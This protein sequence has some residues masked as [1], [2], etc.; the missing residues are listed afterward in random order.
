MKRGELISTIVIAGIVS[1]ALNETTSGKSCETISLT[2]TESASEI[3]KETPTLDNQYRDY[4]VDHHSPD[5][6]VMRFDRLEPEEHI[7]RYKGRTRPRL[8]FY[9][10]AAPVKTTFYGL[11]DRSRDFNGR[12]PFNLPVRLLE[13]KDKL[14]LAVP[15]NFISPLGYCRLQLRLAGR[16]VYDEAKNRA[17]AVHTGGMLEAL[18]KIYDAERITVEIEGIKKQ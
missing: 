9:Q 4:I 5:S 17:V 15:I 10:R 13:Q 12:F 16:F 18:R 3:P 8:A 6:P 2:K 14:S 11:F 7:R 1:Q